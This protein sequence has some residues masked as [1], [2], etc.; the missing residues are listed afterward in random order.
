MVHCHGVFGSRL[1][2]LLIPAGDDDPY[3]PLPL[4]RW[5]MLKAFG[6]AL[7]Y[8]AYLVGKVLYRNDLLPDS[9]YDEID[10]EDEL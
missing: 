4:G 3:N 1:V 8:A 7:I 5:F 6:A 9:F 10:E 2:G